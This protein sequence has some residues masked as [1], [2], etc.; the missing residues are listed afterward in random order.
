MKH[1]SLI[2]RFSNRNIQTRINIV[3]GLVTLI[4]MISFAVFDYL[5]TRAKMEQELDYSAEIATDRMSKTLETPLWNF[6]KKGA[7]ELL[8]SEMMDNS[9][10]GILVWEKDGETLYTGRKRSEDWSVIPA[11]GQIS[12]DYISKS[13]DIQRDGERIGS[14]DVFYTSRF[15][16]EELQ[17]S[18]W[19]IILTVIVLNLALIVAM[20][21]AIKANV[22][23]PI[24]KVIAGLSKAADKIS[25]MS[26]EISTDSQEM[27]DRTTE[28]AA[29]L[30]QSSSSMEEMS[31]MIRQNATNAQRADSLAGEAQNAVGVGNEKMAMMQQAIRDVNKSS[32][33]TSKIIKT[34]DEIAFQ[35]NLLALNAA[36]EAAR[37]GEAG[38]GFAVV[39]DEVR[40]L[41]QRAAEAARETSE[42]IEGSMEHTERSVEIAG[43]V[44][45][46]LE[47][48][49]VQIGDMNELIGEISAASGE[50]SRG[51]E[52]I[53]SG[54]T[55]IDKV[56]QTNAA[57]AEES[58]E[59][60]VELS[61]LAEK[62]QNSVHDLLQ[63][64]GKESA[65]EFN[66]EH[67]NTDDLD[68]QMTE[69]GMD[70]DY[71]FQASRQE[72]VFE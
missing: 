15:M 56:T 23:S 52:Q 40:N 53:N 5:T 66:S 20:Y 69:I 51:I 68:R 65:T 11:S 34:I 67:D 6:D 30:Q 42:L 60:A 2:R 48:I 72:M 36:V 1:L 57:S 31:S 58:A 55:D 70:D 8:A 39:A 71:E 21:F 43:E 4:V 7:E 16:E 54:I 26:H 35:T 41:S 13:G 25:G 62:L 44:A 49:N 28:Q 9:I 61:T 22:I 29:S 37:A 45:E 12:G 10:Y 32:N 63:L 27:A 18:V 59:N 64:T 33:E 19:N 14:V 24:N 50:Q 46:S 3:L 17:Q 38:Q 47:T